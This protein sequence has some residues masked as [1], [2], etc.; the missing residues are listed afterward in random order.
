[1]IIK[2]L[3]EFYKRFA[4]GYP[5]RLRVSYTPFAGPATGRD[6]YFKGLFAL[7]YLSVRCLMGWFFLF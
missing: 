2:G 4:K 5:I 7:L 6:L 1:L 3:L